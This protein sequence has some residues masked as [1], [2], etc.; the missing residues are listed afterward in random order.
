VLPAATIAVPANQALVASFG[1]AFGDG[2]R[3]N[4]STPARPDGY[5]IQ[6]I[7]ALSHEVAEW[8]DDPSRTTA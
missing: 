3:A 7:H 2:R 5:C 6:D 1:P 8:G 4:S